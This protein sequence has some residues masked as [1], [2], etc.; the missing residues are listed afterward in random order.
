MFDFSIL[1][2]HEIINFDPTLKLKIDDLKVINFNDRLNI[3]CLIEAI[4]FFFLEFSFK[5][6]KKK[7]ADKY[8]YIFCK[9]IDPIIAIGNEVDGR[10]LKFKKFFPKKLSICFQMSIYR[11]E[12]KFLTTKRLK[13]LSCDYFFTYDKWH[14]NYFN[15]I[16]SKFIETGSV[17]ANFKKIN[18]EEKKYEILYISQYREKNYT[19]PISYYLTSSSI[20]AVN[21]YWV[22][23]KIAQLCFSKKKKLCLALVS[24]R[25]DKKYN[26]QFENELKFFKDIND[27]FYYENIDNFQLAN[28]SKLIISADSTMGVE[29]LFLGYKVLFINS[30]SFLSKIHIFEGKSEEGAFWINNQ[31]LKNLEEKIENLIKLSNDDYKK[32]ITQEKFDINYDYNNS[33]LIKIIKDYKYKQNN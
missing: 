33:K 26:I 2:K 25:I 18:E 24:N 20:L 23:N 22:F 19:D 29:L 14:T 8:F 15:F 11:K 9:R 6:I 12:H 13:N 31:C 16:K 30:F 28:K 10:V 5:D 1:K 27:K 7:I 21:N 17:K 32:I 3:F 4:F